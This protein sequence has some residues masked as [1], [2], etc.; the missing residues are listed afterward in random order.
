MIEDLKA[1][2]ARWDTERRAQTSRNTP[3]GSFASRDAGVMPSGLSS[4]SPTVQYR[5]S[6]THQSRQHHGPTEGPYQQDPYA[7]DSAFDGPRYPGTGASGYT[8]ASGAYQQQPQQHSYGPPSGGA[9]GYQQAPSQSPQPDPRYPG[10]FAQAP[11]SGMDRG[12]PSNQDS[13]PPYVHTGANMPPR[14]YANDGYSG[15]MPPS[16]GAPQQPIYASSAPIQPGYPATTSP[17]QYSGQMPPTAGGGAPYQPMHPSED[18]YGRGEFP[19]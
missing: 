3:G 12:F 13:Q 10:S 16:S 19:A 15:R 17:Y 7:R 1:D 5:M 4:N 18:P 11:A 9:Y 14:G 6:E 2:S 8:G